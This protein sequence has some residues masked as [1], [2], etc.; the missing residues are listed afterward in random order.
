MANNLILVRGDTTS[1][2]VRAKNQNFSTYLGKFTM[3]KD[4]NSQPAIQKTAIVGTF[5]TPNTDFQVAIS[6]SDWSN[7]TEAGI[8]KYDFEIAAGGTV[9]T[10]AIGEA[11]VQQDYS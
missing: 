10:I 8:Y 3:R 9:L 6:A 2:T 1:F 7:C 5:N 4:G 11:E